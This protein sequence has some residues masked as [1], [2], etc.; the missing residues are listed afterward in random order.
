MKITQFIKRHKHVAPL[1][2]YI[3]EVQLIKYVCVCVC[4]TNA[5]IVLVCV[6]A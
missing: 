6:S 4:D 1:D 2:I 5:W 3:P